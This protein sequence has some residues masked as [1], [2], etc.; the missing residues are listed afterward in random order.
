MTKC[1]YCNYES[2]EEDNFCRMCGNS[3][4]DEVF[5]HKTI[6]EEPVSK[7]D[8]AIKEAISISNFSMKYKKSQILKGININIMRG[9]LVCLLG[10]SGSGKSIIIESLVGR[11]QPSSGEIK[12]FGKDIT[13]EKRIYD[14]VGFVPQHAELYLNQSVLDN[15]LT[16]ALKWNIKN[17]REKAETILEYLNLESRKDIKAKDLSGGQ[18]KL[19]SLGMELIRNPEL[20][21]L[22]EP[23]SGLDPNTRNHII[24]A[25]SSIVTQQN[26]T[27]LFTTHFME[28]AEE[29]DEVILISNQKIVAEGSPIR[30]IK[31]LPGN[32]KIVNIILDNVTKDLLDKIERLEEVIKVIRDGRNLRIISNSPNAMKLGTRISELG[33]IVNKA[34]IQ[35][36]SMM[37]VFVY[38]TEKK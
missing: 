38:Y 14:C 19:L 13:Q 26:K 27:V 35:D 29:C 12:I 24:T 28:D 3:L 20:I 15:L 16:S 2:L 5:V 6:N 32:G 7:I 17:A 30:L 36:A 8:P 23:T 25:L 21:I 34:E 31:R 22:D 18:Q 1:E 10:P 11:K 33:A 9:E 37:E 4:L